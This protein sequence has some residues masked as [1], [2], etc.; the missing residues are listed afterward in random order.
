[1]KRNIIFIFAFFIFFQSLLWLIDI[2][3][4]KKP[5]KIDFRDELILAAGKSSGIPENERFRQLMI[6]S[7]NTLVIGTW[8]DAY[9]YKAGSSLVRIGNNKPG[10]EYYQ[11][12]MGL[13]VDMEDNIYLYSGEAILIFNKQ[14][15][16]LRSLQLFPSMSHVTPS[17]YISSSGDLIFFSQYNRKNTIKTIL[18][19][20]NS[21]GKMV[22]EIYSFD[23]KCII[24]INDKMMGNAF[25]EYMEDFFM[26]PVLTN[27]ICFTSNTDVCLYFYNQETKKIRIQT[28]FDNP[29]K[30]SEKE[31]DII[32]NMNK[33]N[34]SYLLFPPHRP[35]FQG[36]QSDEKGRIYIFRTKIVTNTEKEGITT[37]VLN[38]KGTFLIR[39]DIP[40]LPMFIDKG[41]IF[42]NKK[43]KGES[44]QL[45]VLN[46]INY[47]D[48]P[49]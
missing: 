20:Y 4:K 32:K 29:E 22:E 21:A 7:D 3:V 44:A 18:E 42:Y 15:K 26:V 1:M 24:P 19:R 23:S 9:L 27:E 17:F 31:R 43:S 12:V 13:S 36:M 30:I 49:L 38:S 6:L 34:S 2:P 37:D 33:G 8:R 48:F 28:I 10:R 5:F 35:F 41:K 47:N 46:I 45:R 40:Y 11:G 14:G 16:F 25:H 39:F